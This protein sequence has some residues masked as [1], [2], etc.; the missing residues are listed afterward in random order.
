[1]AAAVAG[2]V[3]GRAVGPA[4]PVDRHGQVFL[5]EGDDAAAEPADGPLAPS[6]LLELEADE[7]A[8]PEDQIAD[9]LVNAF[10]LREGCQ[11]IDR[12]HDRID[13]LLGCRWHSGSG[14]RHGQFGYLCVIAA[15][16]PTRRSNVLAM[17]S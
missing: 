12:R 5:A 4:S 15:F 7:D 9:F 6:G 1:M 17:A 8:Q 16:S 13:L 11:V 10:V 2:G 14:L 3:W